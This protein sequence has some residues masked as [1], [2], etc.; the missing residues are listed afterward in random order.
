M[1]PYTEV[2]LFDITPDTYDLRSI[3]GKRL[4]DSR[5]HKST[6]LALNIHTLMKE[7]TIQ[8]SDASQPKPTR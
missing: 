4:R 2:M 1:T 7:L 6:M 3:P 5:M 8:I